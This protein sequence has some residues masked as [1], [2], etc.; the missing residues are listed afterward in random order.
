[1]GLLEE[2]GFCSVSQELNMHM[3]API[4][5]EPWARRKTHS[6]AAPCRS[7]V[8]YQQHTDV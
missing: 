1:M 5:E 2:F 8:R 3:S 7:R 6:S 4:S